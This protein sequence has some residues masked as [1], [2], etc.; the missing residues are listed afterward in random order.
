MSEKQATVMIDA[1]EELPPSGSAFSLPA[2]G[3]AP[4]SGRSRHD[5]AWLWWI[6]GLGLA[7]AVASVIQILADRREH[8]LFVLVVCYLVCISAA[9]LCRNR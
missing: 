5:G 1:P 2:S 3:A 8:G 4:E 6:A 9:W 7:A